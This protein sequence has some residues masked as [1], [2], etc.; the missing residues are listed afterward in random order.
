[1]FSTVESSPSDGPRLGLALSG[2]GARGLAHI[3]VLKVFE[4]EGILADCLAGT[5]MGGVIAAAYAAGMSPNELGRETLAVTRLRH[6]LSLADPELSG[7]GLLRGDR[8][9]AFFERQLGGRTFADLRLQLALVAVDLNTGRE[10][11]LRQ[12]SVAQ[13][14]RATVSVPGVFAPVEFNGQRLVDGGVLNSVP[15]DV[16]RQMGG[17]VVIAVDVGPEVGQGAGCWLG[18][19]RWMPFG[20]QE[21]LATLSDTMTTVRATMLQRKVQEAQPDVLIRPNLPAGVST[22]WGYGRARELIAAGECAGRE[23]IAE[24]RTR[25][26][27]LQTAEYSTRSGGMS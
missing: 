9:L 10:V 17:E 20:L 12:G 21:T 15:V 1:M 13:A 6:L 4:Q 19:H 25:L 7:A 22:L 5:S 11:L 24:I 2:G 3:G 27:A 18:N 16:V 26:G 14:L 8:L 23:A